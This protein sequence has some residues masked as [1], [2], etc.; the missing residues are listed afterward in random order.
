V[1]NL[2]PHFI[3]EQLLSDA[4]QGE[5]EAYA[6]FV[7]LSGFT[8]LTAVL[9]QEG[10]AGAERLSNILNAIFEPMVAEVY[11]RGGF[12]PYF[13]GDAFSGIFPT[14]KCHC[15]AADVL[16]LAKS[17]FDLLNAA[18]V[19]FGEFKIGIK[20]GLSFGRIEWGI[21]GNQHKSFYFRG[22]AIEGSAEAQSNAGQREII[23]D[24][25]F[26]HRLPSEERL[27]AL[28]DSGYFQVEDVKRHAESTMLDPVVPALS[29]KVASQFLKDSVI[30]FNQKGEFRTVVPVFIAF[31]GVDEHQSLDHFATIVLD[32]VHNFSGYFKEIDFGDKGGVMVVV[33][34]APVSFENNVERALEFICA[35]HEDLAPI[36]QTTGLRYKAGIATGVAYTGIVGG[37]ERC[38]YAA[39]GNR[40]NVAARLMMHA[41]WGQVL[42]D[43][44]VQKNRHFRFQHRGDFRYKGLQEPVPTWLLAGRNVEQRQVFDG[45]MVGRTSELKRLADF[46][47][48][49]IEQKAPSVAYVYGEPGI[50]KTRLSF[51]LRHRLRRRMQLSWFTCQSDQILRKPFNPFIYLLRN[52]FEQAADQSPQH[53]LD[54]FEKQYESLLNDLIDVQG[55]ETEGIKREIIRTKPVLAALVGLKTANSLWENLD[56]KGR[57]QN[58]LAALSA[59]FLAEALLQPVVLELED[60]HWFDD[61][62]RDFLNDLAG[63]IKGFPAFILVTSRYDDEGNKPRLFQ[64]ATLQR[65]QIPIFELDLNV[66]DTEAMHTFACER[67]HHPVHPNLVELLMRTANGNP[68]YAEQMLEYFM[69]SDLLEQSEQGWVVTDKN[70]GISD[71]IQ[72]VLTARI[73]RL[74]SLV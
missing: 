34:G 12:I 48:T 10:K 30:E 72:A 71:S 62:S 14:S 74:S 24:R 44:E 16:D 7:D 5:F 70:V 38:Q 37:K 61:S 28:E 31:E 20:T 25:P 54:S 1:K 46:A 3:Q 26:M 8:S 22:P 33:W 41:E 64:D 73:D 63:Q 53:N 2:V 11:R 69:E 27:R 57:Y 68:F 59:F 32:H 56:A 50:G 17:L 40:V 15:S 52:Y 23:I 4:L 9:M 42:V 65:H 66:L 39:V 45:A 21:V 6:M 19:H 55:K 35:L 13:A 49:A 29:K 51:E 58:T 67:L 18:S 43:G 47:L 36:Q 60:G